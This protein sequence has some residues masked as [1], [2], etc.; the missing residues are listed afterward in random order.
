AGFL[1]E[2][3]GHRHG[4]QAREGSPQPDSLVRSFL[5]QRTRRSQRSPLCDLCVLCG[6][7]LRESEI[8][9]RAEDPLLVDLVV[10]ERRRIR[11]APRARRVPPR[12]ARR[13]GRAAVEVAPAALRGALPAIPPTVAA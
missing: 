10:V 3:E 4:F 1:G 5:P 8:P 9:A 12:R 11:I 2:D 13:R 6:K 7:N